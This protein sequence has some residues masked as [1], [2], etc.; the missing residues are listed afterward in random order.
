MIIQRIQNETRSSSPIE[1]HA[2]DYFQSPREVNRTTRAF[3]IPVLLRE[4]KTSQ[5]QFFSSTNQKPFIAF[6]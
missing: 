2:D 3:I 5:P 1:N 4:E 6:T